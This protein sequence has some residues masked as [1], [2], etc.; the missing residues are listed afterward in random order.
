MSKVSV[1]VPVYNVEPYLRRCIDSVLIQTYHD[2]EL[3][4]VDDGSTD[5]SGAICDVYADS[6]H[7]IHVI[8]QPNKG[9]SGAR[10]TAIDW[11]MRHSDSQWLMFV[12]SDDWLHGQ[13]I[14]RLLHAAEETGSEVSMCRFVETDGTSAT[15]EVE[16]PCPV[17]CSPEE[18]YVRDMVTTSIACAKLY[19]KACFADIRYPVGKIHEDEYVTHRILFQYPALALID[20]PLYFYYVNPKGITKSGWSPKRLQGLDAL[21]AQIGYY[22]A[23]GFKRAQAMC[24]RNY[25]NCAMR[26]HEEISDAPMDKR[27]KEK[28]QRTVIRLLAKVIRENQSVF[29]VTENYWI[30]EF[31]FPRGMKLYW[32]AVAL[33]KKLTRKN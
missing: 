14:E 28:Y 19:R 13:M 26:Q 12:D 10:N 7:R 3:I 18:M 5:K 6:D 22:R 4:L 30:Y 1:I 25:A 33:K 31:A 9:L 24:V 32:I 29:P 23:Q 27:E 16:I 8:H 17:I 11:V 15:P 21:R 20:A 2:F